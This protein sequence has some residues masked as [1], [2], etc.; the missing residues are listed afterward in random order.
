MDLLVNELF[1]S[2]QGE[3]TNAGFP[4]YFIRLCGCNLDCEYCDTLDARSKGH[5]VALDEI[6]KEVNFCNS[7]KHI[8]VTGGE[9]LIQYNSIKL[10]EKLIG[11]GYSV[12]LETN[13]SINIKDVPGNVIKIVDVKTPSSGEMGTFLFENL[14]L[15]SSNDELKFVISDI[16]DYNFSKDFIK[17]YVRE[18]RYV[19]NFSPHIQKMP[20]PKLAEL[21]LIDRLQVRLNIQLHKLIWPNGEPKCR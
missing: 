3:S 7:L 14:E 17:T 12:Q 13:G 9:P 11:L 8:T 2:I 16:R 21:I 19:I 10:L 20:I 4:T 15:M 18:K 1:Y 5:I 6:I